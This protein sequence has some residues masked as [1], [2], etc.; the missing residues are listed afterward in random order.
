MTR[1]VVGRPGPVVIEYSDAEGED[2]TREI[3]PLEV[4]GNA[5]NDEFFVTYLIA[6]CRQARAR[7]TFRIDRIRSIANAATGEVIELSSWVRSLELGPVEPGDRKP[8]ESGNH[9][10]GRREQRFGLKKRWVIVALL[11]GYAIGRWRLAR[12]VALMLHW[13]WARWI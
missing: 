2:S 13:H 5:H 1:R 3:V 4:G 12:M 6:Q 10:N 8:V 7:R 9:D 11:V